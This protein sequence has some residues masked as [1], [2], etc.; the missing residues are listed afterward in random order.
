MSRCPVAIASWLQQS[1]ARP[2]SLVLQACPRWRNLASPVPFQS[3]VTTRSVHSHARRSPAGPTSY[4][5]V[6]SLLPP[7]AYATLISRLG[8]QQTHR[9]VSW[10]V[11]HIT[12]TPLASLR[13]HHP[14]LSSLV[15][16]LP[17]HLL[18]TLHSL[19]QQRA[20]GVPLQ[21]LLG[22]VQWCGLSVRCRPPVLIPRPETEEIVDWICG[23]VRASAGRYTQASDWPAAPLSFEDSIASGPLLADSAGPLA[24]FRVLDLCTGSGC[25]P[26]AL[27][28]HLD[29][30][31]LGTDVSHDAL[32]LAADN[33]AHVEQQLSNSRTLRSTF[34]CDDVR[35][36]QLPA[37]SFHLVVANPPYIATADIATLQPEVRQHEST[38][39]LDGGHDGTQ[40]YPAI[41]ALAARVLRQPA[42]ATGEQQWAGWPELV[43]EIG[44]DEQRASVMDCFRA[45]GFV[46]CAAFADRAGRTR[47]IAGKRQ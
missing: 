18:S 27:A 29:C 8:Q 25:I 10:L 11:E 34:Q 41:A 35:R 9:E 31:T 44:G 39:A 14:S 37:Q 17:A 26:L 21:Y 32:R 28:A 2:Q 43:V 1:T 15:R 23:I 36:S 5:P 6:S 7:D 47:W 13:S 24:S 45:A 3:A 12:G 42:A 22:D 30:T 4:Q 16:S 33:T 40:L 20:S 46:D 19:V 38:L